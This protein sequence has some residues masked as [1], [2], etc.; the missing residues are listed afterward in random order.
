VLY[1]RGGV[2]YNGVKPERIV[3]SNDVVATLNPII[4]SR[5][6]DAPWSYQ[7]SK[8]L[9]TSVQIGNIV[10]DIDEYSD[11]PNTIGTD[12]NE[13]LAQIVKVLLPDA[14]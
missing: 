9:L 14:K 3:V 1:F 11:N 8:S 12:T 7:L 2:A 5:D 6:G 13:A 4:K 10:V